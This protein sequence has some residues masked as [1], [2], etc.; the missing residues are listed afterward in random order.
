VRNELCRHGAAL[1]VD[2]RFSGYAYIELVLP[3]AADG[4]HCW[5]ELANPVHPGDT[6]PQ[7]GL[8]A[9]P[10]GQALLFAQPN[11]DGSFT[12]SLFLPERAK[13]PD[14]W[15]FE[16]LRTQ[17]DVATF[18]AQLFPDAQRHIPDLW[19]QFTRARPAP[20]RSLKVAPYH[21]G[22]AALLGDA[23]HTMVPF[24]GQ[25]VNSGLEDVA[26][27]V[28][29]LRGGAELRE[30]L[31]QYSRRRV[32]AGQAITDLSF[33]NFQ[34]LRQ[35]SADPRF[36]ARHRAE[37]Q[38]HA[39]APECFQPLLSMVSFSHHSYDEIARIDRVQQTRLEAIERTY[40]PASQLPEFVNAYLREYGAA[41]S[42]VRTLEHAPS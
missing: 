33:K 30:V 36:Q 14:D 8:H 22:R 35:S 9:W 31:A 40:D 21:F 41:A 38:I 24:F 5:P 37:R 20:L 10:R 3:P 12:A 1:E 19:E 32:P 42:A 6:G 25:G 16:K 15:S 13:D 18:F 2:Q 34:E 11:R 27:L 7:F 23:A 28:A 4:R 29:E 39:L 26:T 17:N